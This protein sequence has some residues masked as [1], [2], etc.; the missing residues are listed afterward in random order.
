M[1][2]EHIYLVAYQDFIDKYQKNLVAPEEIGRMIVILSQHF[3]T[4]N[5]MLANKINDLA[6]VADSLASQIDAN[7]KM[8]SAAKAE[9]Q[10]EATQ[11]ARDYNV[12]KAHVNNIEHFISALTQLQYGA[13]LEWKNTKNT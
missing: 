8:I 3:A 10:T 6:R 11:E 2:E 12:A 9:V 7:G 4:Y 5:L 1:N 13:S